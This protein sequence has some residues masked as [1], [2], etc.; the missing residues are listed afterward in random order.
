M[1][2]PELVQLLYTRPVVL[3]NSFLSS[4]RRLLRASS[5]SSMVFW[6]AASC[7]SL[8]TAAAGRLVDGS[9]HVL[10]VL[11]FVVGHPRN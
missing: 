7:S 10:L 6:R 2:R 1:S 3:A 9:D 11:F 8:E 4:S 5:A